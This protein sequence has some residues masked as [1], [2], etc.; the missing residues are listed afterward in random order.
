M[1]DDRR[2]EF[3][4]SIEVGGRRNIDTFVVGMIWQYCTYKTHQY[5]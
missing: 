2:S 5:L 4:G 1:K 3:K